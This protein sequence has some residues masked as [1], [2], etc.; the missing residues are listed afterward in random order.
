MTQIEWKD[1][2]AAY[3]DLPVETLIAHPLNNREHTREQLD[4]L[5]DIIEAVGYV[6]PV[7]V[8]QSTMLMLD[9]HG[10][11]QLA[12]ENGEKTIAGILLD[13]T[14][15]EA[16]LMLATYN[17]IAN[18]A[19]IRRE[20]T[21]IQLDAVGKQRSANITALLDHARK[22][23]GL[24]EEPPAAIAIASDPS[25]FE[26]MRLTLTAEQNRTVRAAIAKVS[27]SGFSLANGNKNR[28]GNA[29][30][31]ICERYVSD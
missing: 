20:K 4:T 31:A 22:S 15:P 2:I 21:A 18:L 17:P 29:I 23:A 1:K 13:L 10:R 8:Q 24:I 28:T 30:A 19:R 5:R 14:D 11:L 7:K 16:A 12:K 27:A 9:G 26:I 3:A 25:P 6:D